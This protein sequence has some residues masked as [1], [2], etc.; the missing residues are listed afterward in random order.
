MIVTIHTVLMY[1]LHK[2]NT[3]RHRGTV[4]HNRTIV[5]GF[6][7]VFSPV[8]GSSRPKKVNTETSQLNYTVDQM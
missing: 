2:T 6:D 5:D 4:D 7:T 8:Y 1:Q 3:I